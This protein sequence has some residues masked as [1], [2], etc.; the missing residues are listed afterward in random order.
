ME[1]VNL[2]HNNR[3]N[4]KRW[5]WTKSN[6]AR[7]DDIKQVFD[8]MFDYWPLT[9]RQAYYRLIS[10]G[11][12]KQAH[13]HKYSNPK[14]PQVDIYSAIGRTLKWMRIDDKLPW[15]AI[16]DEHRILTD[17]Q[18]YEGP[19]DFINEELHYIFS[20][21]RRCLAHRQKYHIE[22]WIEKAALLSIVRPVADK[23]CRR[24]VCCKGYNSIT[25]QANFYD[26]ASDALQN[27][28]I[29][30]VLYFGD[31]DPSGVDMLH[32]AI[33][34]LTDELGLIG[35]EYWRCGINQEHF[36]GLHADPIPI[37]PTDTRAKRFVEQHGKTAY[38]L[39]AFHPEELKKLVEHSIRQFT[40]IDALVDDAHAETEERQHL[41]E[42]RSDVRQFV[43]DRFD[44]DNQ[45]HDGAG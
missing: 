9:E 41:A 22:V 38:E 6:E 12:T 40:N 31:W 13:W 34:T 43:Y 28:Q 19:L 15:D 24:M 3:S 39:D 16:A 35:V 8:D 27:G 45:L 14:N 42:L 5:S 26:R 44:I 37:K 25:F 11:L 36:A 10:S 30:V 29:P 18:G 23:Y 21:Y 17:K 7:A 33:Q 4:R 2:D 32:S 20:G 1:K